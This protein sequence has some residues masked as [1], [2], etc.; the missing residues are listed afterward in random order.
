MQRRIGG[1]WTRLVGSLVCSAVLGASGCTFPASLGLAPKQEPSSAQRVAEARATSPT[2]DP[3]AVGATTMFAATGPKKSSWFSLH[4]SQPAATEDEPLRDQASSSKAPPSRLSSRAFQPFG[5]TPEADTTKR[6][7]TAPRDAPPDAPKKSLAQSLRQAPS[8]LPFG[9]RKP[10]T[11][12][13]PSVADTPAG[14]AAP[15]PQLTYPNVVPPKYRNMDEPTPGPAVAKDTSGSPS[16]VR[17]SRRP[18]PDPAPAPP[19]EQQ[20]ARAPVTKGPLFDSMA[21]ASQ[22]WRVKASHPVATA[23]E[24]PSTRQ[25]V[26]EPHLKFTSPDLA[27]RERKAHPKPTDLVRNMLRP[28]QS[29]AGAAGKQTPTDPAGTAAAPAATPATRQT[30]STNW[31]AKKTLTSPGSTLDPTGALPAQPQEPVTAG[32]PA[33]SA[34]PSRS[35]LVTNPFAA[36]RAERSAA[37]PSTSTWRTPGPPTVPPGDHSKPKSLRATRRIGHRKQQPTRRPVRRNKSQVVARHIL[38]PNRIRPYPP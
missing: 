35:S 13:G 18:P 30:A 33:N 9:R 22:S 38:S 34:S 21:K 25:L 23:S 10:K 29:A 36:P 5:R 14:S 24:R 12:D 3:E 28:A 2:P 4:R 16:L 8:W 27:A 7:A 11:A 31:M 17:P 1:S 32:T 37:W 6:V 26:T 15:R 19:E 20:V